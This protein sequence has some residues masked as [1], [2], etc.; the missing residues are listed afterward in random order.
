MS[1]FSMISNK[2]F[3]IKK[4]QVISDWN[5]LDWNL[6]KMYFF[7]III[8]KKFLKNFVTIQN[9]ENKNI[10]KKKKTN[11]GNPYWLIYAERL[12][13]KVLRF[14]KWWGEAQKTK[15]K[16]STMFHRSLKGKGLQSINQSIAM[17]MMLF[18]SSSIVCQ[19]VTHFFCCLYLLILSSEFNQSNQIN[20]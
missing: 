13:F 17:K 19:I 9:R 16:K 6:K 18:S 8:I 3:S 10:K 11:E 5:L 4:E 14:G 7:I 15:Q 2:L 1:F 12:I 20:F